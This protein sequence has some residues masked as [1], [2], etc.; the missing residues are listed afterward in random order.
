MATPL[1]VDETAFA[2]SRI[3]APIREQVESQVRQA[4]TT[5]RFRPGD[6]LIEREL[7]ALLGVS[8]TS[9]REALRQLEGDGLVVNIPH[10]GMI[11][12]MVTREEA[13]EIYQVRAVVEGLAGR[14]FAEQATDELR[15]ALESAMNAVEAALEEGDLQALVTAKD[16]FYAV[17]LGGCGNRTAGVVLQSLHDRI[18]SLR[19]VTLAQPGRAAASVAEMR[20]M[21]GAILAREPEEA[22]RACI[23]HVEGAATVAAQV[24]EQREERPLPSDTPALQQE[25]TTAAGKERWTR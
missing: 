13:E 25:A 11:V 1:P 9:L 19:F 24:F 6:R 5:G 21:L 17:L 12:A 15:A 10:K 23:E 7:C 4:I 20:R 16:Q 18:A 2:I 3:A 8:R 22:C 14:L